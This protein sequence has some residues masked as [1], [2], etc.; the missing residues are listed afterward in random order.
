MP[1]ATSTSS[2]QIDELIAK[3]DS[4]NMISGSLGTLALVPTRVAMAVSPASSAAE[5]RQPL[6]AEQVA[7]VQSAI[8]QTNAAAQATHI[9]AL[10]Q[11]TTANT[12]ISTI[13]QTISNSP[14]V[15]SGITSIPSDIKAVETGTKATLHW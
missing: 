13:T 12:S 11:A 7:L 14:N 2:Q 9:T 6:T 10:G 1:D 5:V 3:V 8:T 15:L 4:A